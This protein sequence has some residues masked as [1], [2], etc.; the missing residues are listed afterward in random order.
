MHFSEASRN[1][2][3]SHGRLPVS[4]SLISQNWGSKK[5]MEDRKTDHLKIWF[6]R[7]GGGDVLC[8]LKIII[9]RGGGDFRMKLFRGRG[10]V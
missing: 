6:G 7:D 4:N 3:R 10:K 5:G 9:E 2:D 1:I 8:I